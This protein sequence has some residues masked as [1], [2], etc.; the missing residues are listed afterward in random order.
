[1]PVESSGPQAG[2]RVS[3]LREARVGC[4]PAGGVGRGS[5]VAQGCTSLSEVRSETPETTRRASL[6]KG[7]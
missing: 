5:G 3:A 4:A 7:P 6:P 1:M 2:W